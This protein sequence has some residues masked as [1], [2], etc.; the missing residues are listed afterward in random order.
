M[1][2]TDT[3]VYVILV[4]SLSHVE[5]GKYAN[6][7]EKAGEGIRLQQGYSRL[8]MASFKARFS[9]DKCR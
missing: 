8:G 1:L 7:V 9:F 6:L 2:P 5:L 4:K 3:L